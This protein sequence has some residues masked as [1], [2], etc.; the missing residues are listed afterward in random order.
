MATTTEWIERQNTRLVVSGYAT[1]DAGETA[2]LP[3]PCGGRGV[4]RIGFPTMTGTT[5]TFTVQAF[6]PADPAAPTLSPPFRPV[7]KTDGST[8]LSITVTDNS[9]V[10]VPSL[11]GCYAFTIVS[12]SA[13]ASARAIEVQM[14]GEPAPFDDSAGGGVTGFATPALTLGTS[15][16]AGAAKTVLATN[17]TILAFDATVPTTITLP[18]T[19]ATGVATVAAR[20]DHTHGAPT[21]TFQ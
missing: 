18:A 19:A 11:S 7:Y 13:E 8:Q 2:T 14:V 10:E 9:M 15:N 1:I 5:A 17:S 16:V 12:G 3:I 4:V 6:P 20:R 21:V